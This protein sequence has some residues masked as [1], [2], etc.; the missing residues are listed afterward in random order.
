[1]AA[2]KHIG[3]NIKTSKAAA[4]CKHGENKNDYRRI[5]NERSEEKKNDGKRIL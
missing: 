2:K 4:A 1:M 3:E 5:K